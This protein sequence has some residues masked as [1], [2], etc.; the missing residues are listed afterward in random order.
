M[1]LISTWYDK[2]IKP[3][4]VW[5][6]IPQGSIRGKMSG[7][8]VSR[9]GKQH[10]RTSQ[11]PHVLS[12]Q[13]QVG[14]SPIGEVAAAPLWHVW[15][16]RASGAVLQEH[17]DGK[18]RT[19][20]A[21]DVEATGC[22]DS[23]KVCGGN[24]QTHGGWQKGMFWEG[25]FLQVFGA[26]TTPVGRGLAGG[27]PEVLQVD[28]SLGP[29]RGVAE[30]G[31]RGTNSLIKVL[32][33]NGPGGAPLWGGNLGLDGNEAGKNWGGTCGFLAAGDRD[34]GLKSGGRYL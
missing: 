28:I 2:H 11:T 24:L 12:L 10:R 8:R 34:D 4:N 5:V 3:T 23:V 33:R 14:G 22:G 18:I 17:P 19:E 7:A 26:C 31:G 30:E 9:G 27:F 21:D 15:N 1:S 16:A 6:V 29:F 32:P 25:R 13:I 20:Y